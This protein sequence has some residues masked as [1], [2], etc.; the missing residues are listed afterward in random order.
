MSPAKHAQISSALASAALLCALHAPSSV[1]AQDVR[2]ETREQLGLRSG[3]GAEVPAYERSAP[4][5]QADTIDWS[6]LNWDPSRLSTAS[7]KILRTAPAAAPSTNWNRSDK[8]DGSSAVSVNRKLPTTW[9]S[10]VGIDLNLAGSQPPSAVAPIDPAKLLP[11]ATAEQSNGAAWAN[12]TAPALDLPIGWDKATIDARFDPLQEQ[13]KLGT[14]VSK[15]IP[16]GERWSIT[17]QNGYS[18]TQAPQTVGTPVTSASAAPLQ[19]A[20]A[21]HHSTYTTDNSAKLNMLSTGTAISVGSTLSSDDDKWL[22]KFSAEQKLFDGV[23]VTGSVSESP[24]GIP[25]RSI[26]AGFK[27]T[28]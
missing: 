4:E 26:S 15:S 8:P 25:T 20:A 12:V 23:S 19:G 10:K 17:V 16:L 5:P 28:W 22:R 21:Q 24:T 18:V 11:G 13:R 9:D 6:V 1:S 14:S 7:P 2:V 3:V 27:R